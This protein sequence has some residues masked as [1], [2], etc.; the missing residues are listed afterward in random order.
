MKFALFFVFPSNRSVMA[1]Y[2]FPV[3][4]TVWSWSRFF[5]LF[6]SSKPPW[7]KWSSYGKVRKCVFK[8]LLTLANPRYL[9]AHKEAFSAIKLLQISAPKIGVGMFSLFR[10]K[11]VLPSLLRKS[12]K[13]FKSH[14]SR[15]KNAWNVNIKGHISRGTLIKV[16]VERLK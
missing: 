15:S 12:I 3:E 4:F 2:S 9:L 6:F 16:S 5:S 1:T 11:E 8:R 10:N 13:S 7:K 14:W